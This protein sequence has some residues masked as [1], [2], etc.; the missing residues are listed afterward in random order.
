MR[1]RNKQESETKDP[2]DA[3]PPAESDEPAGDLPIDDPRV[4]DIEEVSEEDL[5][6]E[7]E[8]QSPDELRIAE[9][10]NEIDD[11]KDKYQ[12]S[13]A[14]FQNYQRRSLQNERAE[15]LQGVREVL[16]SLLG[17]LDHFDLALAQDIEKVTAEQIVSGVTAIKAEFIRVLQTKGVGLI[18][19]E[20]GDAFDP[21]QHEAVVNQ[22][23]EGIDPGRIAM[24]LQAGYTIK[25]RVI[26]PAK[27]AVTPQA[28]VNEPCDEL[29]EPDELIE[30]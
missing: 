23:I 24:L 12:R 17:V 9:L 25:D 18:S 20:P 3:G 5:Q 30:D 10:V 28:E 6:A 14:D 2:I 8:S 1:R 26:R 27:V 29:E 11:L 13:L 7:I 21:I 15:R 22:A 4:W 19:P 16:E